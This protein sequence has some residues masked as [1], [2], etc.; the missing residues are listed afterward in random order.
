MFALLYTVHAAGM[1]GD[2]EEE[3]SGDPLSAGI[4]SGNNCH[5]QS[6]IAGHPLP[7]DDGDDG[8]CFHQEA[9]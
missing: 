3:I 5:A 6:I 1:A 9:C 7:H 8:F 2:Y 4:V